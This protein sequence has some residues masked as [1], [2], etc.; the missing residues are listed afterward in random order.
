MSLRECPFCGIRLT[1]FPPL[2]GNLHM[3]AHVWEC[4]DAQENEKLCLRA[5]L[6]AE[7]EIIKE[8]L[9]ENNFK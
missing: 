3:Q 1:S 4:P 9:L 2:E 6:I 8:R 7:E 5:G